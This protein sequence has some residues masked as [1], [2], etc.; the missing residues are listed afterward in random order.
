MSED[1]RWNPIAYQL[2]FVFPLHRLQNPRNKKANWRLQ[3]PVRKRVGSFATNK[4]FFC[5]RPAPAACLIHL[6]QYFARSVR[7]KN[8][9]VDESVQQ[10]NVGGFRLKK[11]HHGDL[12]RLTESSDTRRMSS[13]RRRFIGNR[14]DVICRGPPKF[15]NKKDAQFSICSP[16]WARKPTFTLG[17]TRFNLVK[18][19]KTRWNSKEN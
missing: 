13:L 10:N 6:S 2:L 18:L 16:E 17:T 9:F 1:G 19:G 12:H 8:S 11:L 5:D 3:N 7:S 14:L 15:D 4:S